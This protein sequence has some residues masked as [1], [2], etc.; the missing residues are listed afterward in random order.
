MYRSP[1][2]ARVLIVATTVLGCVTV[3]I[4]AVGPDTTVGVDAPVWLGADGEPLPFADL[5]GIERFL[6]TADIVSNE[7]ISTGRTGPRQLLLEQDGVRARAAFNA[8]DQLTRGLSRPPGHSISVLNFHDY[9]LFNCAAYR[10]DRLLGL[11]RVPPSVPREVK[12]RSGT[13][14]LWLEGTIMEKDRTARGPEPPDPFRWT[15]QKK[16]MLVF[17]NL[18]GNVDRN[19]GNIL[20]DRSWRLWFID[21]TRSFISTAALLNP[22][23]LN[24]CE[25][26]LYDA[27]EQLDEAQLRR[28]LSPFLTGAEIDAMLAR[29]ELILDRLQQEVDRLGE[30]VVLFELRPPG[31]EH[32]D[33]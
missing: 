30:S 11:G 31:P 15:Q 5:D 28:E 25:R 29:R 17:D 8:V 6:A 23:T 18:I 12:G 33:W 16:M 21:H 9:H 27:L 7:K 32:G 14:T 10:L 24:R 26:G 19:L 3:P 13:V 20:I 22:E 2:F 4:I 1:R